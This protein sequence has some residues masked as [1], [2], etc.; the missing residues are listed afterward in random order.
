MR[1]KIK[2]VVKLSFIFLLFY[3][4]QGVQNPDA[5]ADGTLK[6]SGIVRSICN[7]F[8]DSVRV[9]ARFLKNSADSKGDA[10]VVEIRKFFDRLK[11][12]VTADELYALQRKIKNGTETMR[13]VFSAEITQREMVIE[14]LLMKLDVALSSG[15]FDDAFKLIGYWR[16][17]PGYPFAKFPSVQTIF[18]ELEVAAIKIQNTLLQTKIIV[19]K[20][21]DTQN[22]RYDTALIEKRKLLKKLLQENLKKLD[23]L[24]YVFA[25]HYPFYR[26]IRTHLNYVLRSSDYNAISKKTA[27][28]VLSYLGL[29]SQL[30]RSAHFDD[31]EAFK[32]KM[33]EIGFP[34]SDNETTG[35]VNWESTFAELTK[36]RRQYVTSNEPRTLL[37][38]D[39]DDFLGD[40]TLSAIAE[41]PSVAYWSISFERRFQRSSFYSV[42][43]AQLILM[44]TNFIVNKIPGLFSKKLLNTL[45]TNIPFNRAINEYALDGRAKNLHFHRLFS[46]MK[47]EENNSKLRTEEEIE[48]EESNERQEVDSRVEISRAMLEPNIPPVSPPLSS[49]LSPKDELLRR[50]CVRLLGF[51]IKDK[52]ILITA[53][54]LIEFSD[55][56]NELLFFVKSYSKKATIRA[57]GMEPPQEF[58][59]NS[60]KLFV[61][62]T[63]AQS[64]IDDQKIP[65][66]SYVYEQSL[67][68]RFSNILLYALMALGADQYLH[69]TQPL[70]DFI[71]QYTR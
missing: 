56:W 25:E 64:V 5:F 54:R 30:S 1:M 2:F 44:G 21:K 65:N 23:E 13:G 60:K 51:A 47:M 68:H 12:T 16:F 71:H 28:S 50:Q 41:L 7:S 3:G 63:E 29:D 10:Q 18:R 48:T 19:N 62:M 24:S 43:D 33:K 46:I 9:G 37:K 36:E 14:L 20:L 22:A 58:D 34:V 35:A 67:F 26:R 59:R 70:F 31:I 49:P 69:I 42:L 11:L 32:V 8:L 45:L 39:E 55:K 17:V 40:D 53:A 6:P 66:I 38:K 15:E 52:E 61:M 57:E 4:V 27:I